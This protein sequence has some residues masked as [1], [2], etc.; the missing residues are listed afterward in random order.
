MLRPVGVG[1]LDGLL[2]A[3]GND[4]NALVLDGGRGDSPA[5]Q[6]GELTVDLGGYALG[7]GSV[8]GYQDRRGH[9]VVLGL[10]QE[11]GGNECR[12]RRIV[13]D[14]DRLRGTV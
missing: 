10:R 7:E 8:G 13:R 12:V 2:D 1:Q 11:V 5:L 6:A 4:R 3:L 9:L 14:D